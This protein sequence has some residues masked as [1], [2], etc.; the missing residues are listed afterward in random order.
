VQVVLKSLKIMPVLNQGGF[1]ETPFPPQKIEETGNR[2]REWIRQAGLVLRAVRKNQPKQLL[3]RIA[4]TPRSGLT[5]G[6]GVIS[7]LALQPIFDE[8]LNV[9]GEFLPATGPG[10]LSKLSES[11]QDR[12]TYKNIPCGVALLAEPRNVTFDGVANPGCADS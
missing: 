7:P 5:L 10:P 1:S 2:V 6:L 9:G 11:E 8:R 3:D 12:N 4:D